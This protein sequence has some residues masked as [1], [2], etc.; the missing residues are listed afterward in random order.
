M[1]NSR[2]VSYSDT[3]TQNYNDRKGPI[4]KIT[5]HH[6]A[7]KLTLSQ[8]SDILNSGREVSWNYAIS[9]DGEI[10]LYVPEQYRAW[11]SSSEANDTIAVTIE[12]SNSSVGGNWPV[13]DKSYEA[14]IN[15]CEDICR[16]NGIKSL[17]YTGN[18][19]GNLTMHKFFSSTDC[20]GPYLSSKFPDIVSKV[21]TRLGS[22]SKLT[23]ITNSNTSESTS[24]GYA[25][26]GSTDSADLFID[27]TSF[28]PYLAT[29]PRSLKSVN[30]NQLKS[31]SVIGVLLES[32]VYYDTIH[33]PKSVYRNPNLDTQISGAIKSGLSFGFYTP[34]RS[35]STN[36]AILELDAL[37]LCIQK[38]NPTLGVWLQLQFTNS[39]SQNDAILDIYK[40]RLTI[41]GLKGKIGLY[42][43][44]SQLKRISW[45][46]KCNDW[47][48]W[49]DDH[50]SNINEIECV[51][52][53]EFFMLDS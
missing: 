27:Y 47:L 6:A 17:N 9:Y 2:L 34:V 26:T 12:V 41:L 28:T 40:K 16:R 50:V 29:I 19:S 43:S 33:M 4:S 15:L 51:L 39:I 23:Y 36:D 1:S 53:P 20:P 18:A 3:R 30:F 11:T 37:Q 24:A 10:G 31:S 44:R 35:R 46:S 25:M 22:P 21:N 8:F 52:T 48:L 5:I 38:Y 42:C 7:G 49:L 13:S 45:K 32:G 14:L